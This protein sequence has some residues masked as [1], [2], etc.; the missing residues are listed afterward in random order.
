MPLFLCHIHLSFDNLLKASQLPCFL[1]HVHPFFHHL[2][3]AFIVI[4]MCSSSILVNFQGFNVHEY[5]PNNNNIDNLQQMCECEIKNHKVDVE[6]HVFD[7]HMTSL[8]KQGV[9]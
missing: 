3:K 7:M 5:Y 1:L 6:D 9:V 4:F 8:R 2:L